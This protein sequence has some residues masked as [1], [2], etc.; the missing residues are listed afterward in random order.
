M[1]DDIPDF[2][3]GSDQ[4]KYGFSPL[5][6][7][8]RCE[9]PKQDFDERYADYYPQLQAAVDQVPGVEL[10]NTEKYFCDNGNCSMTK[11]GI[12]LYADDDH[13]N[14]QGSAFLIDR[15]SVDNKGLS[16]ALR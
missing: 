8:E 13:M 11:N 14:H 3:F 4:C 9:T 5:L 1:V 15:L 2:P 16:Q 12:L 10:L 7:I 6:P